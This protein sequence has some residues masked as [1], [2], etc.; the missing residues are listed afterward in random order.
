MKKK[1]I[2][3]FT[4]SAVLLLFSVIAFAQNDART[5]SSA[6]GNLYV[7]SAKAGGVNL[8]EGTV[9]IL[10]KNSTSGVLVK[11]D[12]LEVGE[13]V[14]TDKNSK[15]EILLN[16]G[17]YA[18]LGENSEFEFVNTSLDDLKLRLNRGSAIFEVYAADDFRVALMSPNGKFY[19]VESGVYRVDVLE[20]GSSKL[21]VWKGKAQVG[22]VN[23]TKVKKSRE[24][25]MNGSQAMV[26]KFDRDIKDPLDEWS[27]DRAKQLAKANAQ[28]ERK[29][30]RNS[31]VNSFGN[32][33][34]GGFNTFGLWAY[35][36]RFGGYCFLPFDYG[37]SSPYGYG[38]DRNFFSSRPSNAF[39]Y[40][41]QRR[42]YRNNTVVLNRGTDNSRTNSGNR[43]NTNPSRR[44][45]PPQREIN[46]RPNAIPRSTRPSDVPRLD[47]L[48]QRKPSVTRSQRPLGD[49][50]ID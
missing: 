34:W 49:P 43:G 30:L 24:L 38:F 5:V 26:E 27:Q 45:I 50:T 4:A 19:F 23:T 10:R 42:T 2:G 14:V 32:N 41:V 7:I 40:R 1:F 47:D 25:L 13:K 22:D 17:S 15:A 35:D 11:G 16:P 31:L 3:L 21:Q 46:P 37:W 28:L 29:T 36:A 18:R 39:Y 12:N 33:R 9:S 20:N 48:P 44:I 6:A 8:T